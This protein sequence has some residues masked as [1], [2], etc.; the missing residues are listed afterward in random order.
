[1]TIERYIRVFAGL[2]VIVSLALGVEGSPVFWSTWAL[3]LTAFVGLNLFQ[4]GFTNFCPLAMLLKKLGI[5][6][7]RT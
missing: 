7:C 5:P 4:S 6:E 1:M 2:V 3:A